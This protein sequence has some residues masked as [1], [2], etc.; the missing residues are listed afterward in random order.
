MASRLLY[1]GIN[2]RSRCGVQ[3]SDIAP[4]HGR[5]HGA[6]LSAYANGVADILDVDAGNVLAALGQEA[7]TDAELGVDACIAVST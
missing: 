3:G 4:Y 2:S 1:L 7:C 6:A 5:S